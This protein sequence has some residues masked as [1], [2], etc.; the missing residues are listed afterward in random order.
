MNETFADRLV[1]VIDS[2]SQPGH[3]SKILINVGTLDDPEWLPHHF[4]D[5][6]NRVVYEYLRAYGELISDQQFDQ[7]IRA[8]RGRK[9]ANPLPP[10]FVIDSMT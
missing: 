7:A 8:I 1:A 2:V 6:R 4:E 5:A 10:S 3:R 9:R